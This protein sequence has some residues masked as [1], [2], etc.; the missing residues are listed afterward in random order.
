MLVMVPHQVRNLKLKLPT[1][2]ST[3]WLTPS[4]RPERTACGNDT[5][6]SDTVFPLYNAVQGT[7][8]LEFPRRVSQDSQAL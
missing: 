2:A 6:A 4:R 7:L 3:R 8:P 1:T 5:R